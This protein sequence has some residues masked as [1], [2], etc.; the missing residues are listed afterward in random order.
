M[1]DD[2]EAHEAVP[3]ERATRERKA[4][5]KNV[6]SEMQMMENTAST[7]VNKFKCSVQQ[8]KKMSERDIKEIDEVFAA[9]VTSLQ[10]SQRELMELIQQKHKA[11][12]TKAEAHII[13]LEQEA[14]EL[15]RRC[16]I[17]KL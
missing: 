5:L 3:L 14:A 7:S 1:K 6:T 17:D 15:R 4:L 13:Q 2:H 16:E 10:R 9:L 8:S 12:E 11:A